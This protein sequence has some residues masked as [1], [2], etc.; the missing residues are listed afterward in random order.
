MKSKHLLQERALLP[1]PQAEASQEDEH[2]NE[3]FE[4]RFCKGKF[5]HMFSS[6]T[7][8]ILYFSC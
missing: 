8:P 3:A 7:L 4:L 6:E 2:G 1:Q 5:Y